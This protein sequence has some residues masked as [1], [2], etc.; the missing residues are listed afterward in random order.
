MEMETGLKY[1]PRVHTTD[2]MDREFDG[3]QNMD[4]GSKKDPHSS[5]NASAAGFIQF[6]QQKELG[7][8]N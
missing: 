1:L 5:E 4:N 7:R 2:N 8:I 6:I 3:S